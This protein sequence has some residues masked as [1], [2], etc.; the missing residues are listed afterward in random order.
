MNS[1]NIV[2]I[3][4]R[5]GDS[6]LVQVWSL[7][8]KIQVCLMSVGESSQHCITPHYAT[9]YRSSR[10]LWGVAWINIALLSFPSGQEPSRAAAVTS[11]K[12]D[13]APLA[14]PGVYNEES[15][16]SEIAGLLTLARSKKNK[17]Q[18]TEGSSGWQLLLDSAE[19]G[20]FLQNLPFFEI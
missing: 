12:K 17:W 11:L 9:W 5:C 6:Q 2:R 18:P 4:I 1:M 19:G 20:D 8:V 14:T 3:R 15:K 13:T 7:S 10:H 16:T